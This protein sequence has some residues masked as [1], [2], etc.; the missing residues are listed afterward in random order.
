LNVGNF[1]I[2]RIAY[3]FLMEGRELADKVVKDIPDGVRFVAV[4]GGD[5]YMREKVADDLGGWKKGFGINVSRV[6]GYVVNLDDY[7]N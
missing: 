4:V 7:L 6:V 2:W 5:F 3:V 1:F